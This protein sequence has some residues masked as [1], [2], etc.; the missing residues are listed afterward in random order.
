MEEAKSNLSINAIDLETALDLGQ[1]FPLPPS[2][3]FRIFVEM[4]SRVIWYSALAMN[5]N[6]GTNCT[7]I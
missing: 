6:L 2:L 3:P 7:E 1:C 5:Y 4:R